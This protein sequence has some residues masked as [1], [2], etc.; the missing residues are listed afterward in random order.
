[1]RILAFFLFFIVSAFAVQIKDIANTV[2][3]RDNQLIGYGLVVGLNGSGDGTS[4][5]FTLQSVSNLLQGM[6]IKVDPN[7]IKSKNTAAVMVTAKLPAFAKSGDKLDVTVSSLGDAKSLQGGT[8][9]L[10]ALRGIDGEIYAIAQGSLSVGGL[11]PRPG[12]AGSHSTAA[13]VMGG[14]NV[15]REIPQNFNESNNLTLSLKTA[16][17]KTAND[18]ERVLNTIFEENVAKAVDSRTIKLNKPEDLSNVE[19][20]ARVLEQDIAYT[21]QNKVIIDE[22]TGTV[23]AGVDV[24]VEPILITHKDITIKIDPNNS[25]ALAGNEIDMKD[26]GIVD[27]NSNTLRIN[28]SKTTVANIA[29]MLNKLGASPND[30]IAIMENLKRAGAINADLEVI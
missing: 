4:S 1:M 5:K 19:F 7:D 27:P 25:T 6:N 2:G 8:L 18:I 10:T 3:V 20:M 17:F 13:T 14:A 23:I 29:R 15:E 28:S 11:A 21:P 26:G 16:D 24:E 30:I 9:L 12:G 22:R